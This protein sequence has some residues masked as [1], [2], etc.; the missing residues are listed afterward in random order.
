M[1]N[2]F[3]VKSDLKLR[4]LSGVFS[5]RIPRSLQ[6][7]IHW[8]FSST[9]QVVTTSTTVVTETDFFW[10]ATNN[11]TQYSSWL[12]LF[13]QYF[14]A[15]VTCSIANNSPE[16]GTGGVPQVYT[17][18][19]FDSSTPINTL[20]AISAF[21]TCNVCSISPG[22]SVTRIVRPCNATYIGANAASGVTRSWVDSTFSNVPFYG[23]RSIVNNTPTATVQLDYTFHFVWAL[24]NS[25]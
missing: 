16:G 2:D 13:D 18:V 25:I 9:Q 6:N 5:A 3:I 10:N 22:N 15:A 12:I 17:A 1:A 4:P 11:L 20:A 8:V 19:D 14:L 23:F 7:Q 21:S 24:R